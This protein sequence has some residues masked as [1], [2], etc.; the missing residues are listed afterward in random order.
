M[1]GRLT[2]GLLSKAERGELALNLPAGLTRDA[3]A[4]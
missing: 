3:G 2:A 1:R 4:P